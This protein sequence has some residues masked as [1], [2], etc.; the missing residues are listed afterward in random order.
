[1][2]FYNVHKR[3]VKSDDKRNWYLHTFGVIDYRK[4]DFLE[5]LEEFLSAAVRNRIDEVLEESSRF[6][7]KYKNTIG[8]LKYKDT[9]FECVEVTGGNVLVCRKLKYYRDYYDD[10]I[11]NE[12][13]LQGRLVSTMKE[14]L[15]RHGKVDEDERKCMMWIWESIKSSV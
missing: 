11:F 6:E 4:S 3:S 9:P 7:W 14:V 10:C 1:M 15:K 12:E 8:K 2:E 5:I 13:F